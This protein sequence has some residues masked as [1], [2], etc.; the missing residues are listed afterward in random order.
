M[1]AT[2]GAF[3]AVLIAIEIFNNIIVY[4][5]DDVIHVKIVM[6]TALMAISRK[7][8]ILDLDAIGPEYLWGIASVVFAISIGYWLAVKLPHSSLEFGRL[9][10]KEKLEADDLD[11]YA[12]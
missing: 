11:E 7:V 12:E 5:R 1:L 8:I 6:A 9:S 4:L 3:M 2:Y 10:R